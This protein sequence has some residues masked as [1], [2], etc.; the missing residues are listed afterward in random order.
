MNC[1]IIL[2]GSLVLM[3]VDAKDEKKTSPA[4]RATVTAELACLHCEFGQGDGC[5]ACLKIDDKT[6]IVLQGKVAKDLLKQRFDK[7]V[8]VV[9]GTLS[10]DKEKRLVLTSDDAHEY[11]DKDKGQAPD[12]GQAR[13]SGQACC[14]HCD[15]GIGESCNLAVINAAFPI[16]LDG[17]LAT[18]LEI[19]AKEA[20]S[21]TVFGRPFVD[22]KG[23]LRVEA[24]KVDVEKK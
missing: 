23:I 17:K 6:P 22:K 9:Q 8:F 4:A 14:G 13:I 15:L 1:A 5:A 24:K 18:Q 19:E 2:F 11:G 3:G 21:T 16:L 10:I 12:K 7:K 20:K